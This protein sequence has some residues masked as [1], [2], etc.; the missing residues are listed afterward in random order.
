[1]ASPIPRTGWMQAFDE[2]RTPNKAL[3]SFF[4]A[5]PGSFYKGSKVK[6][7][8]RRDEENV[9]VV[10]VDRTGG[11][12]NT[13]LTFTNKEFTP[14]VYDEVIT[15]E[16]GELLNRMAGVDEYS[17]ADIEY[18]AQLTA[19]MIE[20]MTI[21]LNKITRAVELQASQILQTGQLSLTNA[22]GTVLYDLD[23]KPKTSHFP[24]AGADWSGVSNKL[25]D[26]ESLMTVIRADS[27]INC[28]TAIFGAAA[29]NYFLD[30]SKVQDRLNNRRMEMG[31]VNPQL[32]DSGMT[33]YGSVWVGTYSVDIWAY[34]ETYKHPQTGVATNY[35]G[36]DNVILLSTR[37]ELTLSAASVPPALQDPRVASLLPGRLSNPAQGYDITPNVYSSPNGKVIHGELESR[38]LLIPTQIDGFGCLQTIA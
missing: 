24:T 6:I 12:E 35:V 29:L 30:D 11:R 4:K 32:M 8:V 3:T 31:M 23:F 20:G 9:A 2:R 33:Y 10:V 16:F 28:A 7:D 34:P 15:F 27:G 1:M 17:A 14:P 25:S 26:L 21:I 36:A 18:S 5:R 38:P 22:S 19:Q 13:I 37:T